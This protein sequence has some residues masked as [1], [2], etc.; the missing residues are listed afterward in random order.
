MTG[1]RWCHYTTR[2]CQSPLEKAGEI[3]EQL[4]QRLDRERDGSIQKIRALGVEHGDEADRNFVYNFGTD[5]LMIIDFDRSTISRRVPLGMH[6][7]NRKRPA[8][9]IL[10]SGERGSPKASAL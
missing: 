1:W 8:M 3:S 7:P 6:S 9:A 10:Q 5:T 2:Q 4:R